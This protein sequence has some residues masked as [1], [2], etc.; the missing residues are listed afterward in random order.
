MSQVLV[1]PSYDALANLVAIVPPTVNDDE[2]RG[3]SS[4][5]MWIDNVGKQAYI[6]VSSGIGAA[7]WDS[8]GGIPVGAVNY[9]GTWDADAND[10]V[11]G[12]NGAGGSAGDYRI[13]SIAGTTE[14]D[15]ENNWNPPDWIVN[16]GTQWD[17][18]DNT[19]NA[20]AIGGPLHTVDVIANVDVLIS[21]AKLVTASVAHSTVLAA[22]ERIHIDAATTPHTGLNGVIDLDVKT[23]TAWHRSIFLNTEISADVTEIKGMRSDISALVAQ[24]TNSHNA[25]YSELQ[26]HAGDVGVEYIAYKAFANKNG[27]DSEMI[28]FEA[29]AEFD[30]VLVATSGN[31]DFVDYDAIIGSTRDTIGNGNN[32]KIR[33]GDGWD[34][35]GVIDR[36]GGHLL[37]EPGNSDNAGTPGN[38]QFTLP[39]KSIVR[40]DATTI[41]HDIA[42]GAL[43]VDALSVVA[44]GTVV[45]V[46]SE[47][48]ADVDLVGITSQV[49]GYASGSGNGKFLSCFRAVP[50][51]DGDDDNPIYVS[52]RADS[53][54]N[55]GGTNMGAA[56]S[57]GTGYDAAFLIESGEVIFFDYAVKIMGETEVEGDG[58]DLTIHASDG[59]TETSTDRNGGDLY[60]YGGAK[61]EFG[62]D[63]NVI[64]AYS[65]G[66]RGNVGIG[67]GSQ[68][69]SGIGVIGVVNASTVPS[70]D[71]TDG[72]VLYAE[73]GALKWRGSGG[74]VT[75]LAAA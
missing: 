57:C 20:H 58:P 39:D 64:L 14:I 28:A 65:F 33:A 19:Q 71:P 49:T 56:F 6:C 46:I 52:Y 2:N 45:N 18:V 8:F 5:S 70:T 35:G 24:G 43:V 38:I 53:F 44:Q 41:P 31:I 4:G 17:K 29:G 12:N 68:F 59:Y 11:L 72:G 50:I 1:T 34:N 40:I 26:G 42:S 23:E 22:T 69:G 13:V 7:D 27:G 73:S 37:F 36:D 51:G 75:Q 15:G 9:V 30:Y 61:E 63:G 48:G 66:V 67:T 60:L 3:Y 47:A 62:A 74:T 21:D 25:Y 16:R 54:V 10:P 32:L 55:N